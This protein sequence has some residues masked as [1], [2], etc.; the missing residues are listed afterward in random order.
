MKNANKSRQL[1]RSPA[2]IPWAG[3]WTSCYNKRMDRDR[4][5]VLFGR[6]TRWVLVAAAL[7]FAGG[8]GLLAGLFWGYGRDLPS[9]DDLRSYRP[10]LVTKVYDLNDREI[11]GFYH[12]RREIVP[13]ESIPRRLKDAVI[14]VEDVHF[15]AHRG[16]DPIGILRAML[17]NLTAGGM[18]QGGSTITQQVARAVFLT[19]EK[20]ITRKIKEAIL[21]WRLERE[22][23]KEEILWLYLNHIYFGAGAY[24]VEAAARTYFGKHVSQLDL[25]ECATLAG[26][27]KAPSTYSPVEHPEAAR[28]RRSLVLRRMVEEGYLGR[29]EMERAAQAPLDVVGGFRESS[30]ASFFIEHVRR[31][32]EATYGTDLLYRGGLRVY[33]TLDLG[34]Q[35]AAERA[36]DVGVR[37]VDRRRGYRFPQERV[38]LS[39]PGALDAW[40]KGIRRLT[41]IY[42]PARATVRVASLEGTLPLKEMNW[43][44]GEYGRKPASVGEILRPGL[45]IKVRVLELGDL[46]RP[47]VS[48]E[49]DPLVEGA[50]VCLDPR[51]G[52]LRAMVGGGDFGRSQFNRAVQS[53]R[54]PGSAFKPFIYAA[55]IEHGMGPADVIVDSPVVFK[56]HDPKDE[57]KTWKP[58]NY[59]EEFT[60]LTRLRDALNHSRNLP[61][62]R[63][64]QK[65]GLPAVHSL[66]SRLGIRSPLAPDLSLALGSSGV[67]LLE[68]TEAYAVFANGGIH[69]PPI[70]IRYITD[71][72]G[73]LLEVH[74]P[75]PGRAIDEGTAYVMTSMLQTVV[76]EGT[77]QRVKALN[78]V[79]AGKTGTTNEYLDAW[80]IGFI[81]QLVT[82]VW[83]GMDEEKP[84]GPKET[85]SKA[86]APIWLSFMEE[87]V[88]GMPREIFPVPPGVTFVKVDAESGLLAAPRSK[89]TV[90]EVFRRGT[91]PAERARPE[92]LPAA[93]FQR[94][95]V[96]F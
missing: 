50:L 2:S 74:Q 41:V 66:A 90:F 28:A 68:L 60:G 82:G 20:K 84:I 51:D 76:E 45:V 4:L 1:R 47:L 92:A 42:Y 61:T 25:A 16:I 95:D 78:R 88:R 8:V 64:L 73:T 15:L 65:V 58:E 29:E 55:A 80:F 52:M 87:A 14:S 11:T 6:A 26:L 70:F 27:P 18:V 94:M 59:E 24:G 69:T 48:L 89:K 35:E 54:Q 71:R 72:R 7:G 3:G 57:L 75:Q 44:Y 37:E 5:R 39:Q 13:L 62:I 81:P 34:L 21:A 19:P 86:A 46:A 32:L 12:E 10:G 33:T 79:A 23:S 96:G 67:T 17:A 83:V 43:V 91:E 22:F 31:Y 63:L 49:Q 53:R 36:I 93:D 56:Y 9:V 38:D 40:I 85:G 77:G 30:R